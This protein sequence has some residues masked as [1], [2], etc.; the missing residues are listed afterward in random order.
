MKLE[1]N[2]EY[3]AYFGLQHSIMS[4]KYQNLTAVQHKNVLGNHISKSQ[5]RKQLHEATTQR[6]GIA[7]KEQMLGFKRK[8]WGCL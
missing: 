3:R 4:K 6:S 5:V 1:Q 8:T 2:I 7:G